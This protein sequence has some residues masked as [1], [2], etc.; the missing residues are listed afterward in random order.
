MLA[1]LAAPAGAIRPGAGV[2]GVPAV[3]VLDGDRLVVRRL[4]PRGVHRHEARRGRRRLAVHV[5]GRRRDVAAQLRGHG[6][7]AEGVDGGRLVGRRA[8]PRR[9]RDDDAIFLSAPVE[10]ANAVYR[11]A[12]DGSRFVASGTPSLSWSEAAGAGK[13]AWTALA[14]SANGDTVYAA[15]WGGAIWR[16]D[17]ATAA[18]E[19]ELGRRR[20]RRPTG[21]RSR[22]AP[23]APRSSP[24]SPAVPSTSP[25]TAAPRGPRRPVRVLR[26]S[27]SGRR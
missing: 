9:R 14:S 16:G 25:P 4:S 2:G 18:E 24:P 12:S 20:A 11:T 26:R 13:R 15:V 19:S 1:F 6:R 8:A 5:G 22:A 27:A 10:G 17:H 7:R 23:T 21:A 3:E